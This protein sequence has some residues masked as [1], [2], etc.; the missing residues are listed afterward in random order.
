MTRWGLLALLLLAACETIRSSTRWGRY[1][2]TRANGAIVIE[3]EDFCSSSAFDNTRCV[4][5]YFCAKQPLPDIRVG[6]VLQLSKCYNSV[7][8]YVAALKPH[9]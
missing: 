7:Q 5:T 9:A 8:D 3:H 4:E 2:E 6:D 1:V